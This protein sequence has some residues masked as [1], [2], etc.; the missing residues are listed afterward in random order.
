LPLSSSPLSQFTILAAL[1]NHS[2]SL[3]AV[4]DVLTSK[5]DTELGSQE[6]HFIGWG[7]QPPPH[8]HS[9]GY[10]HGL[11]DVLQPPSNPKDPDF[12]N[13]WK[14]ASFVESRL[15][16]GGGAEGGGKL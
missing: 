7:K 5:D 11:Y 9:D 4:F 12:I 8:H 2:L 10:M 14:G 13:L 15:G 6:V 3:F 16:E 1:I